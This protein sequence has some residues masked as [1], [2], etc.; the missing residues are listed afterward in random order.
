MELC[1][2][3]YRRFCDRYRPKPKPEKRYFWGTK[4]LPKIKKG[5][6]KKSPGQTRL[7]WAS[8]DASNPEIRKVADQFIFANAYNPQAAQAARNQ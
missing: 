1:A 8:W 3:A 4:L 2:E 6:Q 5:K 7:P